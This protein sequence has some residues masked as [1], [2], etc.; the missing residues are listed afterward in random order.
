MAGWGEGGYEE[1]TAETEANK[2]PEG[3]GRFT[4]GA[5]HSVRGSRRKRLSGR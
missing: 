1:G 5:E 2:E 3:V 4:D